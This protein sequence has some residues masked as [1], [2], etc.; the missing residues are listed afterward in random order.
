MTPARIALAVVVV[1]V[2]VVLQVTLLSRLGLPGATPDLVLV[3]TMAYGFVRGPVV[4]ASI[5]FS[6]GILLD[7]MPPSLGYFGLTA[8]LLAVA[9]FIAGTVAERSGGVVALALATVAVLC[10]GMVVGR[11]LLAGLLGDPRITWG[12]VP[13]LALTEALYGVI[14]SALA[15]PMLAAI[16][17]MMEP[18][19]KF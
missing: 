19:M 12:E 13:V 6:A 4:G 5:G 17:R 14:L 7:L 8:L 1:T 18:R 3:V 2:S 15:I 10:L 9:G 16:D 11:A